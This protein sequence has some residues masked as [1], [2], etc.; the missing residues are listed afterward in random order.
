MLRALIS[1]KL[2]AEE[3]RLGVPLDYLR[4]ILRASL[5]SFFT[6]TKIM[7]IAQHR[8]VLPPEPYYVARMV[9]TRDEDCGTCL[10]IEVNLATEAAV[11]REVL[12]AVLDRAP[13]R[14]PAELAEVYRFAEGVV[15][16][17]GEED[18]LRPAIVER[19][20]ERGLV[21]LA[22]AIAAARFF[23]ITKRTLGHATSCRL[24]EI[25]L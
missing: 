5:G 20:G 13:E 19:W 17:S 23:P 16:A 12:R 22:M 6:F 11:G 8:K 9:A 4:Q 21:E 3:R 2:D 18:G 7:P 14:L 25:R 24:V 10:Q 15:T 1:K